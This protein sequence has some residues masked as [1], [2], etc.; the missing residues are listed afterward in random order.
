MTQFF[1]VTLVTLIPKPHNDLLKKEN[2][3]VI[4]YEYRLKILNIIFK[5]NQRPYP[6]YHSAS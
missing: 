5:N 4:T 3:T 2:S 1:Y 6:K